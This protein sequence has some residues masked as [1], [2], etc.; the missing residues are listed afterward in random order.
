[1]VAPKR[2]CPWSGSPPVSVVVFADGDR[3]T[4]TGVLP[5]SP[6]PHSASSIMDQDNN[7]E[8]GSPH[9]PRVFVQGGECFCFD[10]CSVLGVE[11]HWVV[12]LFW[13]YSAMFVV[14]V[15][16]MSEVLI[17]LGRCPIM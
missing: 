8:V 15:L 6:P 7:S 4:V 16:A 1:M 17:S 11:A 3:S 13:T 2:T 10:R 12:G 9:T 5:L 14:V